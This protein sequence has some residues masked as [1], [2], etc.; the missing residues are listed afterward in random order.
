MTY[1]A[2][3]TN[4]AQVNA[5]VVVNGN[6]SAI[7]PIAMYAYR[8]TSTGLTLHYFG[9][10]IGGSVIADGTVALTLSATNYVVAHRTTGAVTA[11][12]NTTNWDDT[13]VYGRLGIGTA[14]A[15]AFTYVDWREQTGGWFDKTAASGVLPVAGG[16][17]GVA[18]L[19]AYAPIFGGT[20]GTGAVQSGTVG[21]AGEVLTSNGAGALPTFQAAPG[22]GDALTANPLSQFAATTSLQLAGVI[23]DET[24]S[25]P[26]V[27][28]TS[29]SLVTPALGTP[30]SGN[31]SSCT[32]DGT[33][34]VGFRHIPQN[35]QST[36]YT[37]VLADAGKHL[38]HPAA[39]TNARTFTIDSNA[40]VAYA[41]GTAITFVNET[42]QVVSIAITSDTL[43]LAGS[44]TTGTRSLAQNGVA[45]AIKV[46]STKWIISGTGLT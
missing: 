14:T 20:T 21:A 43:T 41:L 36:A 26:L 30:A 24:G 17:T 32:A 37:T 7:A 1:P 35:S 8:S 2:V 40:N 27:F 39:D 4:P 38:L 15:S 22:G 46:T 10:H 42:S 16:G 13:S 18:T 3:L 34:A 9:G 29:P 5:P 23:S 33:N 11:A 45:T 44:T 25:G 6:L 28:A 31:L 19:T 12:T